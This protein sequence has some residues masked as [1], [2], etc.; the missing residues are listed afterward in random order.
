MDLLNAAPD[1]YAGMWAGALTLFV[2]QIL[3]TCAVAIF[4]RGEKALEP[5]ALKFADVLEASKHILLSPELESEPATPLWNPRNVR[6]TT[7][8]PS[9]ADRLV[10]DRKGD[11]LVERG[12][13]LLKP[14]PRKRTVKPRV[15]K[16]SAR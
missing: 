8:T 5:K 6:V 13:P 4:L 1:F 16:R 9:M 12:A 14:A 3:L 2:V 10:E 15:R 11:H 7:S